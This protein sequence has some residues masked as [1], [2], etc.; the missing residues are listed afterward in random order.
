MHPILII[1][2]LLMPKK[3]Y[4]AIYKNIKYIKLYIPILAKIAILLQKCVSSVQ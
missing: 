2:T 4:I 3:L 1:I